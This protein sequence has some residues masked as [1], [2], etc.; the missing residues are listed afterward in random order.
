MGAYI[1]LIIIGAFELAMCI[2]FYNTY[3]TGLIK[4][5]FFFG[6]LFLMVIGFFLKN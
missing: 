5:L 1:L 2:F 3:Y 6:G 4:L